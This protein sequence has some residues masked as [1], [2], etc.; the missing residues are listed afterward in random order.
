MTMDDKYAQFVSLKSYEKIKMRSSSLLKQILPVW[1]FL[2]L[3]ILL[4]I[5]DFI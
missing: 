4:W 5:D 3:I 2:L 1:I